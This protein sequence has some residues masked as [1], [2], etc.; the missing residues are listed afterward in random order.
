MVFAFATRFVRKPVFCWVRSFTY[1]NKVW[2]ANLPGAIRA[3]CPSHRACRRP[4]RTLQLGT[5]N[6]RA[7]RSF[8]IRSTRTRSHEIPSTFL[9][10]LYQNRLRMRDVACVRGQFSQPYNKVDATQTMN[11]RR[12]MLL[13][14]FLDFQI[15]FMRPNILEASATRRCTSSATPNV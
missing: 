7:Q 8:V 5:P 14:S 10:R 3:T 2:R 15:G 6:M 4:A 1:P 12:F 9:I 11:K 13:A